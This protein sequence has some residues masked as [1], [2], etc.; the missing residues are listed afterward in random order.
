MGLTI[1]STDDIR[2]F[3]FNIE[4]DTSHVLFD[5]LVAT[6]II[7]QF[8]LLSNESAKGTVKIVAL[9]FSGEKIEK[10]LKKLLFIKCKVC[11]IPNFK[12]NEK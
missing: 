1:K 10:G 9:S 2:G 5:T 4:Y 6:D 7:N 3:Q 12:F 8:T 11:P